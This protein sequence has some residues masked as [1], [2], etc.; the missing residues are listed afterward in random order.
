LKFR[1]WPK[2]ACDTPN[3][4]FKYLVIGIIII[5]FCVP[6]YRFKITNIVYGNYTS[7]KKI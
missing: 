6:S 2:A 4:I 5:H 3:F 7:V 1:L